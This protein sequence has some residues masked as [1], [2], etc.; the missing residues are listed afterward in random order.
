MSKTFRLTAV[1]LAVSLVHERGAAQTAGESAFDPRDLSGF[2]STNHAGT[3]GYRGMTVDGDVPPRT[4][5]GEARHSIAITGRDWSAGPGVLPVIGNDPIMTCNPY[6]LPRMFFDYALPIEFVQ[7]ENRL[8]MFF[9]PQS[10]FRQIWF[11]GRELPESPPPR[12]YGYSAGRW[13]GDTLVIDT[14]GIDDRGW[15]DMYGNVYRDQMRWQERWRRVSA[16]TMEVTYRIDDPKT[17]QEPWISTTK[18]FRKVSGVEIGEMVC[19][20]MDE[21]L[22]NL[23]I[24]DP[25]GAATGNPVDAAKLEQ[26]AEA[27]AAIRRIQSRAGAEIRALGDREDA[28]IEVDERAKAQT[29]QAVLDTGLTIEEYQLIAHVVN[30][31]V[32]IREE[33]MVRV[34]ERLNSAE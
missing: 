3:R 34:M 20:P 24:R 25:A 27:I 4:A 19:A 17:Y 12:W 22:F 18:I 21:L 11:D 9:E 7:S 33:T 26:F 32:T 8:L 30:G 1:L 6:A 29:L 23:S 10:V 13:E 14:V 16:D 31:D 15:L 5:W 2:W 28:V